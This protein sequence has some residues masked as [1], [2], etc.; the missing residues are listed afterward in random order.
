MCTDIYTNAV[1]AV[2]L[3]VFAGVAGSVVSPQND[4]PKNVQSSLR[5]L[6]QAGHASF[7][8]CIIK[9]KLDDNLFLLRNEF[10]VV[11]GADIVK[12]LTFGIF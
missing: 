12:E 6:L 8:F 11:S 7:K 4:F 1:V 5:F 3:Q 10:A 2:S 9:E